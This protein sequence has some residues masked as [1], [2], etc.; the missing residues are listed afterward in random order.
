ML[1]LADIGIGIACLVL[2]ESEVK[3][4]PEDVRARLAGFAG[5][6]ATQPSTV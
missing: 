3:T 5:Y 1:T 6:S 4:D 2:W